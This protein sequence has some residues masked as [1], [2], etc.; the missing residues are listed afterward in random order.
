MYR[1]LFLMIIVGSL[2]SC[3][4]DDAT[5]EVSNV[6]LFVDHYQTTNVLSGLA[7]V[8]QEDGQIGSQQFTVLGDIRGFDFEPGYTYRLVATKTVTKNDGTDARTATYELQEV[9]NKEA[10]N[11]GTRFRVPLSTE[12]AGLGVQVFLQIRPDSTYY[13][14]GRI[15]IECRSYC[16]NLDAIVDQGLTAEGIFSH[17]GDGNYVL[18]E[19]LD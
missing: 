18:E 2:L 6:E 11:P 10:A 8:V 5:T 12:V 15:P 7:Y 3:S 4:A 9:L 19:L 13:L 14:S 17:G 1:L 16:G